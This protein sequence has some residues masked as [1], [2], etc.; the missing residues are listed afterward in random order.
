MQRSR[1]TTQR[2]I[3]ILNIQHKY[4]FTHAHLLY[5]HS[6]ATSQGTK[7]TRNT[8]SIS[9]LGGNLLCSTGMEAGAHVPV[10]RESSVLC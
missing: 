9:N 2:T 10:M 8:I 5:K 6:A 7:G 4:V 3:Q 1:S